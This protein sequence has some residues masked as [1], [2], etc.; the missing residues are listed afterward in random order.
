MGP[1]LRGCRPEAGSGGAT[2]MWLLSGGGR[3]ATGA[4]LLSGG[5]RRATGA[6]PLSGGGRRA[7]E[8]PHPGPWHGAR[9]WDGAPPVARRRGPAPSD[10]RARCTYA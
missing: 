10:P 3:R 7:A 4:W 1:P 2:G 9:R 8:A 6:W 5:G